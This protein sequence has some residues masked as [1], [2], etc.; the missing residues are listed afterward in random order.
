MS[1]KIYNAYIWDGTVEEL[2]LFLKDLRQHYIEEGSLH[3][4]QFSDF[5][6]N[7]E[8]E[9]KKEGKY[10][11]LSSYLR[12][13]I[14]VGLNDPDNLDASAVVYF[15]DGKI[16]VQFFGLELFYRDGKRPLADLIKNNSKLQE[17]EYW[18][19]VDQPEELS[20]DQWEERKAFWDFINVPVEDGLSYEFS[21]RGTLFEIISKYKAAIK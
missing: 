12:E 4:I 5:F 8:E 15:Q 18:D 2:V 14:S 1:T 13:R 17:Y 7:L 20:E 10:F 11:H 9:Y 3:M 19:N 16:A 6:K 21:T